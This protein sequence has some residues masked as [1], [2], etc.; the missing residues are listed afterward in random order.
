[1]AEMASK[2]NGSKAGLAPLLLNSVRENFL[3]AA[4]LYCRPFF[5]L[6]NGKENFFRE[7]VR[8]NLRNS[9]RLYCSP[10]LEVFARDA[11]SSGQKVA[12]KSVASRA[13]HFNPVFVKEVD[14]LEL[15][16]RA[17]YGLKRDN[18]M[19]IGDLV[20][21]TES[22]LLLTH[23]FGPK[24]LNE[25]KEVLAQMGLHLGMDVPGWPLDYLDRYEELREA[26][27]EAPIPEMEAP[28]P[29]MEAPIPAVDLVLHKKLDELELS[30]R[31]SGGL[32]DDN[33]VYVGD[34]VQMTPLELL[35]RPYI[36]RNALNEIKEVLAQ[37]GLHLGMKVSDW[38][39]GKTEQST[40]EE[41]EFVKKP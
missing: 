25:I 19:L 23:F 8:E 35:R 3:D 32:K 13:V 17:A 40:S 7:S 34:L 2:N 14:E 29:E 27:A 36:G 22:E 24:A 12:S 16:E 30:A 37:M 41:A 11:S 5:E 31:V 33:V 1:M 10:L 20:Q 28:I 39:W 21:K 26:H 6:A 4:R 38:S 15:S 9:A 18:I